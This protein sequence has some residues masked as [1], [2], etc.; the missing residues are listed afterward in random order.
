MSE[1]REEQLETPTPS[2]TENTQEKKASLVP[3]TNVEVFKIAPD[4]I[5]VKEIEYTIVENYRDA[6]QVEAL[7][8]RY[9]DVLEKYDYIVGDWGFDQL[10]LKGFYD[11]ARTASIEKKIQT[12]QDYLYEYCNFGCAYFV[13]RRDT[14]I[15][16]KVEEKP[17][18][19]KRK[20]QKNQILTDSKSKRTHTPFKEQ[21]KTVARKP[22]ESKKQR[23]FSVK[24]VKPTKKVADAKSIKENTSAKTQRKSFKI[25]NTKEGKA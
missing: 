10:R 2:Q 1:N 24:E 8:K 15:V 12:L 3:D 16:E 9:H 6:F 11:D 14:P 20:P 7:S 22:N 19:R 21:T 17:K 4:R 23:N 18:P 5:R 13:L 25:R